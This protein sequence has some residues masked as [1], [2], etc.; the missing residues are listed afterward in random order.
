MYM[1]LRKTHWHRQTDSCCRCITRWMTTASWQ[2]QFWPYNKR[3][4]AIKTIVKQ[5]YNSMLSIF[6]TMTFS[7]AYAVNENNRC[8]RTNDDAKEGIGTIRCS[9]VPPLHRSHYH[10][11]TAT[12][13]WS[14][15][16]CHA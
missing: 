8:R 4:Y 13:K 14:G 1:Y 16:R 3:A 15:T 2:T 12:L 9:L 5:R 11:T 7:P 6:P 10:R